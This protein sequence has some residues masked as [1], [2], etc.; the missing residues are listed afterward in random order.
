MIKLSL[1][2]LRRCSF[3]FLLLLL[4]L[5]GKNLEACTALYMKTGNKILVGNNEDSI[6]PDT[7]IWFIPTG[8]NG[9]YGRMLFGFNDLSSQGGI[10]EKGLWF[11]AFGLPTKA[12]RS[13]QGE[14]YPGD[15]PEKLLAECATIKDVVLMLKKYSRA[16]MTRYQ[17][18]FGDSFGNSAV[19]EADTIIMRQGN[20]QVIT[21]FRQS[22]FPH[23]R[24]YDCPR[25][26][27]ANSLLDTCKEPSV[28][29]FRKILSATHSEG[30]DVTLY[31]YIA[32]L[33]NG[34]VYVYHFHNF[35]NVVVLDIKKELAKGKHIYNLPDLFPKTNVAESF[36]YWKRKE[37]ADK[38]ESRRYKEFD[39]KTLQEYCGRYIITSP[40]VMDKQIVTISEASELLNLQL[41][42]GGF[43]EL[44]P[45]SSHSFCMLSYGGLDFSCRFRRNDSEI[46]DG[47]I[48]EGSGLSI[49]AKLTK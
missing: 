22:E 3:L 41:N 25:Y 26:Q 4:L 6:N 21:N 31:S 27:I 40:A 46:V 2:S 18:M 48:M 12:V 9:T 16:S 24:G 11:D 42:G 39:L 47:L 29:A 23:G 5:L 20:Y 19:I 36:A 17:W 35:E 13:L 7:R 10:N 1:L 28:D 33:T 37:L 14:I 8:E 34:L 43:Y 49:E 32:D 30:E 38:K 45:E 44:T 15:L